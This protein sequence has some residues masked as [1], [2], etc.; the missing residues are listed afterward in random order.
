M[1]KKPDKFLV[2]NKLFSTERVFFLSDILKESA[3][4]NNFNFDK[5]K[6]KKEI[7]DNF[8]N[9]GLKKRITK[10]VN[11]LENNLS[12][13]YEKSLEI[14]LGALPD[15]LDETKKDGD[16]GSYLF[17]VFG[18]FVLSKGLEKAFLNKSLYALG[19]ITKRFSVEGSIRPFIN[20]FPEETFLFLKKMSLSKNY[21]QRRLASECLRKR[22]P[23]YQNINFNHKRSFEILDNL[24]FD[25]TRYVVRSVANHLNDVAKFDLELVLKY[26]KKWKKSNLAEKK[27]ME[28]L[29]NH[30]LR[31]SIKNGDKK[32]FKFLGYKNNPEIEIVNYIFKD[33]NIE[34]GESIFFEF[35]IFAKKTEKLIIDYRVKYP[36]P[37]KKKSEKVF[38]LK[39]FELE[40][41]QKIKIEKKHFFKTMSTKRLYSGKYFIEILINGNT[42]SEDNFFLKV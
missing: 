32:T 39:K 31:S 23:W 34:I 13:D 2:A 20:N 3:K 42:V 6:F 12:K 35:E 1:N 25:K 40:K 27:E 7:L 36:S 26:L 9:I 4:K 30:A 38:K 15:V 28:Y 14:I 8:T 19:E 17:I 18:D 22:L 21:H 33:K 41:G 11:A 10:I 29:I 5:K 16:F 37:N 24:Y